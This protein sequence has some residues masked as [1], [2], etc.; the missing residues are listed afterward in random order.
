[1]S[2]VLDGH[3]QVT[4]SHHHSHVHFILHL[5]LV[6][7]HTVLHVLFTL[8]NKEGYCNLIKHFSILQLFGKNVTQ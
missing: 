7:S 5:P 1:M 3:L 2:R 8:S 4:G 6:V